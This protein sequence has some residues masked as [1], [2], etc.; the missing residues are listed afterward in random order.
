MNAIV[1]KILNNRL[2]DLAG[3][4]L[5]GQLVLSDELINDALLDLLGQLR[6]T[7]PPA[8]APAEEQPVPTVGFPD[9]AELLQHLQVNELKVRSEKGKMKV[10]IDVSI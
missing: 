1:Q 5:K 10:Q 6:A 9:P 7:T 4:Q 3:S 2:Q 8:P